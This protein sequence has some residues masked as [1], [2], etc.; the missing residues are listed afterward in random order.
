M[1]VPGSFVEALFPIDI[2]WGSVGGSGFRTTVIASGGGQEQRN[3]DWSQAR[4]QW[5]VS[6]G[7]RNDELM[8]QLIEWF[9]AMRGRAIGF[10]F[11]DWTDYQ[12]V[13]ELFG[14]GDANE[15]TFTLR[16]TYTVLGESYERDIE[17][18]SLEGGISITLNGAPQTETTHYA[19]DRTT[20]IVV[21]VTP[22]PSLQEVRWTGEFDVPVRF[23]TDLMQVSQ[24]WED[25]NS[26]SV[27]VVEIR[28]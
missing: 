1:A 3:I 19:I 23:D 17:K 14:V 16:K 18:P 12:A 5:D 24:D 22:P 7:A 13:D 25:I 4:G 8:A 15:K 28:P 2:S 10:R 6:H 20:G 27:K 9:N 21:F 26:W 11:K